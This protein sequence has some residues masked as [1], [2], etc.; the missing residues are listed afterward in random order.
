MKHDRELL[1]LKLVAVSAALFYLYKLHKKNGGSL[2]GKY[3]PEK[4]AGLAAQLVPENYRSE[5]RRYGTM[6]LNKVIQ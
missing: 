1:I 4:I 2:S 3:N 6:I 5:A